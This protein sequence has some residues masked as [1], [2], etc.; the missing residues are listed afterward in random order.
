MQGTDGGRY[1]PNFAP[2][3]SLYLTK[4]KIIAL[5]SNPNLM[6]NMPK[7][8]HILVTNFADPELWAE[9]HLMKIGI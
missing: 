6:C 1:A 9:F 7:V 2:F 4:S 3:T 5:E 8:A